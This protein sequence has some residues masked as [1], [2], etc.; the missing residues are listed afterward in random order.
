VRHGDQAAE[1]EPAEHAVRLPVGE[2]GEL[3]FDHRDQLI[4]RERHR[5]A[6]RRAVLIHVHQEAVLSLGDERLELHGRKAGGSDLLDVIAAVMK[7]ADLAARCAH[8]LGDLDRA[9]AVTQ[10]VSMRKERPPLSTRHGRQ[11]TRRVLA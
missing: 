3:G 2:R 1:V 10:V 6:D 8:R 9:R 7:E 5:R 11:L 4:F